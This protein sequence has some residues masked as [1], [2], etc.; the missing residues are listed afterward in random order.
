MSGY[1]VTTRGTFGVV[2]RT[3]MGS[4][5]EVVIIR[6]GPLG[7]IT[8]APISDCRQLNST[9]EAEARKEAEVVS[10]FLVSAP[11]AP[12]A[13]QANYWQAMA[14]KAGVVR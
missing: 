8:A 14:R 1:V 6:W 9:N 7:W 10:A 4:F 2:V 5:E 3:Y 13:S 12:E 11:P